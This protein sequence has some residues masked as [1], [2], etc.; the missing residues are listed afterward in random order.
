MK[1]RRPS[2]PA[3]VQVAGL[4]CGAAVFLLLMAISVGPYFSG[5]SSKGMPE[6]GFKD[7][8]D[9]AV[10][11]ILR[12]FR[13]PGVVIA[14]VIDGAPAKTYAYGYADLAGRRPMTPDTVF[15]VASISKSLTAWGVLRLV[16][17]GKVRLD[18]PV[19]RYLKTW[20]VA[21]SP[22]PI[23]GVTVRRLLNHTSGLNGGEDS[24]RAPDGPAPTTLA[25]LGRQGPG[26]AATPGPPALVQPPGRGFIYSVPGYTLLQLMI[27]QQTGRSFA[28]FMRRDLI[29][30]LGMTSSS[31][32]WE[33]R[34]REQTA[35]PYTADGRSMPVVV[36]EDS[37][38][39]SLFATA[40]DLAK[41]VGAPLPD[42]RLA[43]GAGVLDPDLIENIYFDRAQVPNLG[44]ANAGPDQP[45]LG[46]FLEQSP[47]QPPIVTNVGFDPG[48]SSLFMASPT[49]GDGI[50]VLTNS[51]GGA[52]AIA[53]I[54]SIWSSWRG[55][56]C[57]NLATGYRTLGLAA[58]S[59]LS[60]LAALAASYA[61]ALA[62]EALAGRRQPGYAGVSPFS[63]AVFELALAA[64]VLAIWAGAFAAV[65][66]MPVLYAVGE[67]VVIGFVAVV[68]VRAALPLRDPPSQAGSGRRMGGAMPAA[69]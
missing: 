17:E 51:D 67:A 38:A 49:T 47:G 3:L 46:Y 45:G 68:L 34:L 29:R 40:P 5:A 18:A 62:L 11:G 8:L 56:P 44:L 33:P 28:D 31:F 50:V 7:Q 65:R 9:H 2:G 60:L 64:S 10:P 27:E 1:R 58:S 54:I 20:P 39:D 55:L 13:V 19:A 12:H 23:E 32:T 6:A 35:T 63:H 24:F 48:W 22:Y 41:F 43:A 61:G 59:F 53:Q 69:A 16:Q 14:T 36:P 21:P 42:K 37:A 4:A 15:R 25:L 57:G 66:T 26:P 52:P 30:P